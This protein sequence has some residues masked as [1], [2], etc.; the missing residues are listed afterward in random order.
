M[1]LGLG[2]QSSLGSSDHDADDWN[3]DGSTREASVGQE[4]S[5]GWEALMGWE[6]LVGWEA[7]AGW[8]ASAEWEVSMGWEV[9]AGWEASAGWESCGYVRRLPLHFNR[10]KRLKKFVEKDFLDQLGQGAVLIRKGLR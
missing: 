7:L 5:A 6:A 2:P 10:T 1:G 8:E 4:A 3:R 9:L